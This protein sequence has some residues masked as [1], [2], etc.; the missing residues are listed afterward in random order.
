[1]R[2]SDLVDGDSRRALADSSTLLVMNHDDAISWFNELAQRNLQQHATDRT[3]VIVGRGR[4]EYDE[5][6]AVS[7]VTEADSA[8]KAVFPRGHAL[9]VKWDAV[10]T[11]ADKGSVYHLSSANTVDAARAIFNTAR[12]MLKAGRLSSFADGIRADTVGELLDQADTFV[13]GGYLRQPQS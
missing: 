11:E 10:L 13:S 2:T 6:P 4:I 9:L 5:A 7:W 3:V 12:D 1:M 8:L